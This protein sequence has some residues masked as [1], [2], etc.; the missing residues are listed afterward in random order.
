MSP[1]CTIKGMEIKLL[2]LLCMFALIAIACARGSESAPEQTGSIAKVDPALDEIVPAGA[3]IEK[4]ATGFAFSEGPVWVDGGYL[5]FS[6]VQSNAM[7]KW[8]PDGTS[9]VFRQPSGFD[10]EL[11]N[12]KNVG[13]NGLTLDKERRL[14]ICE[15]GNRRVTRLE[16]DGSLAI[17]A[18]R[19]EGKRLNSPNDLVYKSDGSLY[20]TD[21]PYGLAGQDDDPEKEL[22]FSGVFRLTGDELQLLYDGMKRPNGLAFSPDEKY[23]YVANS[24]RSRKIWMRFPVQPDGTLGSGSVFYDVTDQ[25]EQG[26]PDGMKVDERGNLYCTGPGGVWIFSPEGRHLGTI[27]PPEIPANCAWGDEDGKTLYIT[28]R[29]GLYRIR[30]NIAGA[31]RR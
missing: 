7:M 21:P 17:L 29:S 14:T 20:F 25:K 26:S 13:S 23:L 27:K 8:T 12:F 1:A 4:L 19:Y 15:H 16:K 22:D 30:L 11:S 5:V 28:A 24:D 18:E 31:G 10:G 3:R 2:F 6:D 9:S